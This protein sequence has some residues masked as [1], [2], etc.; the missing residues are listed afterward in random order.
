M[1][2]GAGGCSGAAKCNV[3]VGLRHWWHIQSRFIVAGSRHTQAS[4]HGTTFTSAEA[5]LQQPL[6]E[7]VAGHYVALSLVNC[8]CNKRACIRKDYESGNVCNKNYSQESEQNTTCLL[9]HLFKATQTSW[10]GHRELCALNWYHLTGM[11]SIQNS[12]SSLWVPF[13]ELWNCLVQLLV[14]FQVACHISTKNSCGVGASGF[15]VENLEQGWSHRVTV[16]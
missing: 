9:F 12:S 2:F 13:R 3:K 15:H 8:C 7:N 1:Y 4:D 10:D 11:L 6:G 16:M 14:T 5:I